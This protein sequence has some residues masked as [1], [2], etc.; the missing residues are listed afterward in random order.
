MIEQVPLKYLYPEGMRK[1]PSVVFL[2]SGEY[3]D[4]LRE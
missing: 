3:I 2:D 1:Y 4:R